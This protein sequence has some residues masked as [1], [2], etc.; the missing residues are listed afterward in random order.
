M[1]IGLLILKSLYFFLPAYIANMAPV[2]FKWLPWGVPIHERKFGRNKTR[3]GIVVGILAGGLVFWIQ[4]YAYVRGFDQWALIDY[5]G[6]TVALGFLLG[7]GAVL[8]DLVKSY[9][10]RRR[11]IKPGQPWPLWDQLDFVIGGLVFSFFIYVPPA[12]VALVLIVVSPFL[13][14]VFSY[15]GYMLKLKKEM[16]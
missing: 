2:L 11:N 4:K 15:L 12:E 8:G 3:R 16:V 13:H 7:A 10:K 1:P 6:F 9:Y 5:G 14:V